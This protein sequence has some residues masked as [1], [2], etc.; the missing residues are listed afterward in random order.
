MQAQGWTQIPTGTG[1]PTGKN[2]R[3]KGDIDGPGDGVEG[4]EKPPG[5]LHRCIHISH[6]HLVKVHVEPSVARKTK[7]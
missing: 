4:A 3:S 1:C 7:L 5:E 6:P 2:F